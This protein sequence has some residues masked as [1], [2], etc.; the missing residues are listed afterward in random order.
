MTDLNLE[1]KMQILR[2]HKSQ[3]D[4]ALRVRDHESLVSAVV[5]GRRHLTWEKAQVWA[6]ALGVKPLEILA[7]SRKKEEPYRG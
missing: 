5:N 6:D 4:F 7:C 1:L 3:A 2:T